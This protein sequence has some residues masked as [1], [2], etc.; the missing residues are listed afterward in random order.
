MLSRVQ[1][2]MATENQKAAYKKFRNDEKNY[3]APSHINSGIASTDSIRTH[4][5][6]IADDMLEK[7]PELADIKEEVKEEKVEEKETKSK[8]K[9]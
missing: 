8:G 1:S 4:A 9:K 7:N 3:E 2:N 6:E 5:K